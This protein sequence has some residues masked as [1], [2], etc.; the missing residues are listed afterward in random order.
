MSV[1]DRYQLC[2]RIADLRRAQMIAI[3][4]SLDISVCEEGIVHYVTIMCM[5][6]EERLEEVERLTAEQENLRSARSSHAS[7]TTWR[8][9]LSTSRLGTKIK[10]AVENLLESI[11]GY[12]DL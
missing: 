6:D 4:R 12:W 2:S 10:A 5:N 9:S 3:C 7:G 11:P 8:R 1:I